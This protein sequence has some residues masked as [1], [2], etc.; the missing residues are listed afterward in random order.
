LRNRLLLRKTTDVFMDEGLLP[1]L[2]VAGRLFLFLA[3]IPDNWRGFGDMSQYFGTAGLHGWP[4]INYW[5]EYP[6]V[7]PFI[8]TLSYRLAGGSPFL[9]DLILC[10]VIGLAGAACLVVFRRI[11]GSL[12]GEPA[13]ARRTVVFFALLAPLP[14]TWWYFDL[15]PVFLMLLALYALFTRKWRLAGSAIGLGALVKWFPAILLPAIW[16]S[17]SRKDAL[18]ITL[19]A[20][21]LVI[22]VFGGLFLISPDMT[23]ASLI[24]QPSRSS[25]QTLWAL[26][27]GNYTTGEFILLKDRL[28]PGLA[29][30]GRGNP[31]VIPPI[32]TLALFGGVGLWLLWRARLED[33]DLGCLAMVGVTWILFLLWS[34]GWSPQWILYL[35]PLILLTLAEKRALLLCL[36]LSLVTLLEW[37]T[38]LKHDIWQGLWLVVPLR[39]LIFGVLL[40]N[41]IRQTR[42]LTQPPVQYH[43]T[44][45]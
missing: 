29:G 21:L 4:Y 28:D 19:L 18:R 26:I 7:F 39:T 42:P 15:L 11:A 10:L 16:R 44:Q 9:F 22:F 24:S 31:A 35:I 36:T 6:P 20:G 25:W 38:F 30:I 33:N 17:H 8:S 14:Y 3:L 1:A 13:A 23:R 40:W 45:S 37:P 5:M 43:P 2:F 27:D 12:W 34:P 41:W 32:L